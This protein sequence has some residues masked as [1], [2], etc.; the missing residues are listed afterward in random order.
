M[1]TIWTLILIAC[2]VMPAQAFTCAD[3]RALSRERQAYYVRVFNITPAQQAQIRATCHRGG[4][5][6]AISASD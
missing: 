1:R 4:S 5:R 6:Q 3:V 2:G